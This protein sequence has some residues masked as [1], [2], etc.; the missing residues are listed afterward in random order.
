MRSG[1]TDRA[2][3]KGG[4]IKEGEAGFVSFVELRESFAVVRNEG[5]DGVIHVVMSNIHSAPKRQVQVGLA[6]HDECTSRMNGHAAHSSTGRGRRIR[7]SALL[8]LNGSHAGSIEPV[9][10][11]GVFLLYLMPVE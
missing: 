11:L 4:W 8:K 9:V 2:G 6:C 3:D 7:L 10:E 1:G 5:F